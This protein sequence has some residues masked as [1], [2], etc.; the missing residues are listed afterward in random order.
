[1]RFGR[2]AHHL[3][4]ADATWLSSAWG[5][6]LDATNTE[7]H[8]DRVAPVSRGAVDGDRVALPPRSWNIVRLTPG[9][10]A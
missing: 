5:P 8:P 9:A 7:E 3:L 1:V 6:S 2:D 10:T 4:G